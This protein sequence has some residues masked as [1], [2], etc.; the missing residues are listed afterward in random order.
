MTIAQLDQA[1]QSIPADDTYHL[2]EINDEDKIRLILDEQIMDG[3]LVDQVC[4]S[5][6]KHF[7]S[8]AERCDALFREG[9]VT[10]KE[11][12]D[13]LTLWQ[14]VNQSIEGKS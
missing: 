4:E 6:M 8:I 7:D 12:I 13:M 5:L 10:R 3:D 1:L 11:I 2:P 14:S 9:H